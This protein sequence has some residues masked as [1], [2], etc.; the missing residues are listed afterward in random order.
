MVLGSLVPFYVQFIY[1][2]KN[3]NNSWNY[4]EIIWH[5]WKIH[6]LDDEIDDLP[7]NSGF[8]INLCAQQGV[9]MFCSTM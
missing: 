7:L 2:I 4:K 6:L 5:F 9:F 1:R 8:N 3:L